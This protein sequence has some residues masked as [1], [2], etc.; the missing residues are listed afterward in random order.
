MSTRMRNLWSMIGIWGVVI[1]TTVIFH[2]ELW[3][4]LY[5]LAGHWI[6]G[7][8]LAGVVIAFLA[9]IALF[10]ERSKIP[11]IVALILIMGLF[12]LL[13]KGPGSRWGTLARFY[14]SK[15]SYETTVAKLFSAR[16]ET[17]V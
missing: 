5:I 14:L 7:C 15:R 6:I 3:N 16:D 2:F 1:A 12:F 9:L 13:I 17:R 10:K 11:T 8:G 4:A